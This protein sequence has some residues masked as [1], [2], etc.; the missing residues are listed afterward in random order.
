MQEDD[1]E[2]T[3]IITPLGLYEFLMMPP[4]FKNSGQ[5]FQRFINNTFF[6]M[7]FVVGFLDDLLVA[8]SSEKEHEEH[9]QF[10]S[11][12]PREK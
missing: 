9:L 8:S 10:V 11:E 2:K 3:A 12:R 7:P 4:G 6:D 1:V 5:T